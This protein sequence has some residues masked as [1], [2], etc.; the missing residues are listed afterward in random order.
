MKNVAFCLD[1]HEISGRYD[2]IRRKLVF[3]ARLWK[4]APDDVDNVALVNI[5]P[6]EVC[7]ALPPPS[8]TCSMMKRNGIHPTRLA[9]NVLR[10]AAT[11]TSHR[12]KHACP[13]AIAG[14]CA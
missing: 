5:S 6:A 8:T 1:A 13:I 10:P 2:V 7:P 12:P 11:L 3:V 4:S 14:G 9:F